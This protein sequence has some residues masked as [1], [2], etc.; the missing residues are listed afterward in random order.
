MSRASIYAVLNFDVVVDIY[1]L[2][3]L[4]VGQAVVDFSMDES[5]CARVLLASSS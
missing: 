3:E 2:M 4:L 5:K 1:Q